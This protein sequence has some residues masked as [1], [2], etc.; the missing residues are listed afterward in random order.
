MLLA[1]WINHFV[2]A[3]KL[4]TDIA[5][6][7]DLRIDWRVLDLHPRSF[8]SSPECSSASFRRCNRRNLNLVPAL[9]DESSMAG[10]RRSRLRN[11]LVIAQI[12][13]SL[14]LLISAGLI[15]RSLQAAQRMRPGFN[16]QNAVALS[17][18][19]G[20]QGYDD[21]KG[22]A[23]YQRVMERV[24]AIP[25]VRSVAVTDMLPLSSGLQLEHDLR[26][27]PAS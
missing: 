27:R 4:P 15:V 7:F 11:R 9:K 12:A 19:L 13:L 25:G 6:V 14:V 5:L 17:F 3:I 21:A 16:P 23:F 10:F 24:R 26:R 20:L 2:S 22:R 18:D 1:A 8:R